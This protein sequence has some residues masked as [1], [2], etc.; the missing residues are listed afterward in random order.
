MGEAAVA[1]GFL[2]SIEEA[3]YLLCTIPVEWHRSPYGSAKR[4]TVDRLLVA[5]G[6]LGKMW[7]TEVCAR[8]R[9]GS[10]DWPHPPPR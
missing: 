2:E 7:P 8:A 4:T 3:L 10:A 5:R 6:D 9:C 1:S